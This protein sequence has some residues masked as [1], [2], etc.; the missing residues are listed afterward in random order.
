YEDESGNDIF[1]ENYDL[2]VWNTGYS[3]C[4]NS[5][6]NSGDDPESSRDDWWDQEETAKYLEA[7]GNLW[8]TG[9]SM[10]FYHD[11]YA[12]IEGKVTNSWLREYFHVEKC[13]H[14]A[15]LR[16]RIVGATIDPIGKGINV[17]D[18]YFYGN[19]VV[20]AERGNVATD[21]IPMED[22]HGVIYGQGKHYSTV[23]YEHQRESS[24]NQRYKTVIMSGGF[25]NFGDWEVID[26]PMRIKLVEK[27]LTW[28]GVPP[29]NAPEYDV[30]ISK[31]NQPMGDY[32]DPG[33]NVPINITL[34][35]FGHKDITGSFEVRFKVDEVGGGNKFQKTITVTDD[36]P[37]TGTL[38]LEVV[39]NNNLPEEGKDYTVTVTIQNPTFTDGDSDNDETEAE[40]TAHSIVDIGI[41]RVWHDWE[42]P[43]NAAMIG[44]DTTFHA[45]I[46]NYGS[47]K[48]TFD[49]KAKMWSPLT[50]IVYEKVTTTTLLPGYTTTL[51]WTWT[52]RN[53]AGLISGYGGND[54]DVSKA[55]ILNISMSVSGDEKS[56]N[57]ARDLEVVVM[58]FFDGSEPRF[59]TEDWTKVDLS[60]HDA[61]GNEDEITPWHIQDNWYMSAS[62]CWFASN[63]KGQLKDGWNTC[64]IS[65]KISLKNFTDTRI[66]N[67]HSGQLGG[68]CYLEL[69]RDY[70]G[71]IEHVEA[72]SWSQIWS[73]SYQAQAVWLVWSASN[74]N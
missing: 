5:K 52:P 13:I 26:E 73:K 66:N 50:T 16:P 28:L 1:L 2:V 17:I 53:P 45:K 7:G 62:H 59:M 25:E 70:D 34:K 68:R 19:K 35:N 46:I 64:I 30:G 60:G 12:P 37:A 20:G 56:G 49:V 72:A 38:E 54:G 48:E 58:A 3:E 6:P 42:I 10:T 47:T 8:W 43:W 11:R 15:G 14:A 21:W 69:S 36:I 32:I 9:N 67:V 51:E 44:Y 39:W 40:K 27:M 41:G 4:L 29:K 61:H 74:L 65:P 18:G 57:D 23:R 71:N 63:S 24:S 31:L 33:H 22:A 55:Y